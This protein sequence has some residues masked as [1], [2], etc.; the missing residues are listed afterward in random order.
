MNSIIPE[1]QGIVTIEGL[2]REQKEKA[3]RNAALWIQY[4]CLSIGRIYGTELLDNGGLATVTSEVSVACHTTAGQ[5][6]W[7]DS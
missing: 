1:T 5:V 3:R 7:G 2:D 4:S 6:T